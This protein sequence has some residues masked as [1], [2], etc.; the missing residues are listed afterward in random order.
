MNVTGGL[1]NSFLDNILFQKDP[2]FLGVNN[3][4]QSA[5][6]IR[7]STVVNC[8]GH[9]IALV[10]MDRLLYYYDPV[11]L[12]IFDSEVAQFCAS[13]LRRVI[14]NNTTQQHPRS[15]SC[16][17]FVMVF[18]LCKQ[19]RKT[20]PTYNKDDLWKNDDIAINYLIKIL[21]EK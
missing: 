3:L 10:G 19:L 14:K 16:G 1:E 5:H 6:H 9:F 18:I 7:F 17:F 20:L 13:D 21:N 8:S 11:G 12:D 4:P 15:I 2:Y